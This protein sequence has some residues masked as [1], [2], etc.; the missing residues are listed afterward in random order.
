MGYIN[1]TKVLQAVA[2]TSISSDVG[3]QFTLRIA[4]IKR[5]AFSS[6][7]STR[8]QRFTSQTVPPMESKLDP[9]KR[10]CNVNLKTL[11]F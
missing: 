8:N 2:E 6:A 3:A 4:F 1:R 11:F 9:P 7:M 10:I 5:V